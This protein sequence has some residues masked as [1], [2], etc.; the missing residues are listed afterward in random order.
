ML[1]R[2]LLSFMVFM[3]KIA[4]CTRFIRVFIQIS[5]QYLYNISLHYIHA[6]Y[7]YTVMSNTGLHVIREFVNLSPS[8]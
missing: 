1:H 7:P 2:F 5:T 4:D 8:G 3:K 6:W